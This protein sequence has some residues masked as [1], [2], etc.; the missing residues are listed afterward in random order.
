MGH[1]KSKGNMTASM[2]SSKADFNSMREPAT[3][4]QGQVHVNS[5]RPDNEKNA[6]HPP[7]AYG[8]ARALAEPAQ[9]EVC[10]SV[11]LN[12][13]WVLP[14]RVSDR[15]VKFE[16][17][18]MVICPACKQQ[19]ERLECGYLHVE[20]KFVNEHYDEIENRLRNATNKIMQENPLARIMSW[21]R[22]DKDG[23]LLITTTTEHLAQ[24]LGRALENSFNGKLELKF[25]RES[26][27]A[28]TEAWWRRDD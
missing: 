10:R 5:K 3:T 28:I 4:K 24:Q 25:S 11:Y 22:D 17:P 21:Q 27:R 14:E 18:T 16:A 26:H 2:N 1:S 8:V 9:C 12:R 13:R 23:S 6:E 7:L 19:S 15:Q 20:G